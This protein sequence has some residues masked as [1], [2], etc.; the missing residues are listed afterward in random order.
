MT[1]SPKRNSGERKNPRL[2]NG[3]RPL[4]RNPKSQDGEEEKRRQSDVHDLV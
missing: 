2:K 4:S 1:G 3:D